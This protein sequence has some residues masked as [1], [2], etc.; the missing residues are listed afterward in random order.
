MLLLLAILPV[1]VSAEFLYGEVTNVHRKGP[2]F[3][4]I[5]A[6]LAEG[7]RKGIENRIRIKVK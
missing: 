7:E 4:L 5:P 3:E 6:P 2:E 1:G